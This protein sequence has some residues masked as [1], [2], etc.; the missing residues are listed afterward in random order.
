[1]KK[2]LSKKTSEEKRISLEDGE[3]NGFSGMVIQWAILSAILLVVI[4]VMMARS[5]YASMA[6]AKNSVEKQMLSRDKIYV[7]VAGMELEHF[8]DAGEPICALLQNAGEW[9]TDRLIEILRAICQDTNHIYKVVLADIDGSG[10]TSEGEHVN[11]SRFSYFTETPGKKYFYAPDDGMTGRA[12]FVATLPVTDRGN[13]LKGNLYLYYPAEE[14]GLIFDTDEYDADSF[15]TLI[16]KEGRVLTAA[17]SESTFLADGN[18]D[19]V[20]QE[21]EFKEDDYDKVRSKMNI[22]SPGVVKVEYQ[23]ESRH[24]V[25]TAFG[26]NGWQMVMG[27]NT[28]Y[29][30]SLQAQRW[31]H[32]KKLIESLTIV[33]LVF[34]GIVFMINYLIR[35]SYAEQKKDWEDKASTD[36]LTDLTNKVITEKLIRKYIEENPNQ[37]CMMFVMDVDNFKKVNDTMGHAF[38]DQILKS[39]AVRLRSTFRMSDVVGRI[40][41]DE[42]MI[43]LKNIKSDPLIQQEADRLMRVMDD[44]TAGEYVRYRATVSIGCAVYPRDAKT[45]EDLYRAADTALY[46]AKKKGKHQLAFYQPGDFVSEEE[47][48]AAGR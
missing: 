44:I 1:M 35:N 31:Y 6:S 40:G 16:D 30:D 42:F 34:F 11:L 5:Y 48:K 19:T 24:L 29:M 22:G 46:R 15:Y 9:E 12:A 25:Y 17:G 41:G 10:I 39:L 47:M 28:T 36:P 43:F 32:S 37:Q 8:V 45:Y 2:K 13:I 27:V 3:K 33:L 4:I 38:G 7:G 20:L 23:G 14:L 26:N 21:A 18:L